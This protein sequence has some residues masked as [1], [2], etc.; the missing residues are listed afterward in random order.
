[1]LKNFLEKFDGLYTAEKI[2]RGML[3][4]SDIERLALKC[5][6]NDDGTVSDI[7]KGYRDSFTSVY[8]DE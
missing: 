8:I 5:L 4:Y 2:R 7:A 1:M 6:Y 3:E